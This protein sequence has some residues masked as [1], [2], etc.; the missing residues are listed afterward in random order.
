MIL[1]VNTRA[2]VA[3]SPQIMSVL[4]NLVTE[5]K[6]VGLTELPIA[7]LEEVLIKLKG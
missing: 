3:P 4:L 2:N 6:K 1:E 5:A 7:S